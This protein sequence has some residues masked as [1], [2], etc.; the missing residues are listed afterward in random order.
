MLKMVKNGSTPQIRLLVFSLLVILAIHLI[1]FAQVAPRISASKSA[2][3]TEIFIR[4]KLDPAK[5]PIAA[6]DLTLSVNKNVIKEKPPLKLEMPEMV[7]LLGG[8]FE[9]GVKDS[10]SDNGP[11]HSALVPSFEISKYPITNKQFAQFVTETKYVTKAEEKP[12]A[13]ETKNKISWKTFAGSEREN[14]PVVWI[15]YEDAQAYCNWLSSVVKNDPVK[16]NA[17]VESEAEENQVVEVIRRQPY[18]LPTEA[19]WEYAARGGLKDSKF[20][21]SDLDKSK[22]NYNPDN[23]RE[24]TVQAA[25]QFIKAVGYQPSNNFGVQDLVGNIAQ[26]CYDWYDPNFYEYSPEPPFKAYGPEKGTDR[27]IRGGSWLEDLESCQVTSRQ[28]APELTRTSQVGFR[29][30]RIIP[31]PKEK[32]ANSANSKILHPKE[33]TSCIFNYP[34]TPTYYSNR[35]VASAILLDRRRLS[36]FSKETQ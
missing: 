29:I 30:V 1:I 34:F 11:E 8:S 13:F 17:K 25:K 23:K 16:E 2:S 10:K 36:S 4:P 6:G 3:A 15:S 31:P 26:W 35:I 9:M 22:I 19:E 27:V 33:I 32:T 12:T 28:S 24:N 20:P 7:Q 5:R 14:H 18:R 21:W